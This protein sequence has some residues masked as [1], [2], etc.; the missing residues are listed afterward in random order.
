MSEYKFEIGDRVYLNETAYVSLPEQNRTQL[1]NTFRGTIFTIAKRSDTTDEN[2]YFIPGYNWQG[3][4]GWVTEAWLSKW[5]GEG[6]LRIQVMVD[7]EDD[8]HE[9]FVKFTDQLKKKIYETI[10]VPEDLL[11]I[12]IDKMTKY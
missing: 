8:S 1:P 6:P 5:C 11:G 10:R 4:T 3:G 7:P 2:Q 12:D 9:E